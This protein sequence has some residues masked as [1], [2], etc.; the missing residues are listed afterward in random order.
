MGLDQLDN[1]QKPMMN[2]I[3]PEMGYSSKT[4]RHVVFGPRNYLG[5]GARDLVTERGVQQTHMFLKDIRSDQDLR[6]LLRIG[7]EW[8]QLHAGIA[9]QTHT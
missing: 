9:S 5:I 3:L 1:I 2:A 6:K 8:F 7:L 4:C